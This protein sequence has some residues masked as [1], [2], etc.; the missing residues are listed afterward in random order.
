M[1]VA[2][3]AQ[4]RR[5]AWRL[6]SADRAGLTATLALTCLASAAGLAG[7]YLLG[8]IIDLLEA[9]R[10]TVAA[11]DGLAAA[12]LAC[13]LAQ[14]VLTRYARLGAFRFGERALARLR[15]EFVDRALALPARVVERSGTGDLTN[16]A[17]GDMGVIATTLRG[18]VPDVFPA[19]LQI[20]FLLAAVF[21]LSPSLGV[22]VLVGV[23]PVWWALHWYLRRSRAAYLAEGTAASTALAGVT[24]T[25]EGGRTVEALGLRRE[26]VAR[27][28]HDTLELY[29][30]RRRTLRLRSVLFPVA[31]AAFSLPAVVV[32]LYGGL[33]HLEGGMSLGVVVAC[34]LYM[35][36][37]EEPA[38]GIMY[39]VEQLQRGGA[40]FARV[41]GVGRVT[42]PAGAAPTPVDDRIEVRG[43]RY[44]YVA[45][46]D[47]LRGIDLT[48]RPGERLAVVGP[49]GAGKTT[50][51]RLLAGVDAPD[52]GSVL[53]GGVPVADL[54]P[55]ELRRRIVLVNQEHHVFAG[56][57]RE[58]L[59][60][61][62]E[63]ADDTALLSAL[64]AVD[65]DWLR[66]LPEGL[67]TP[68]GA[69][70][71]ALDA[72]GAQQLALARVVLADPHTVVL[73]EATSLLDP[74]TARAAERSLA[75]VLEGRTVI[76]IAHRL[77]TA[78]DADRVAVVEDGRI[79]EL[80]T[81]DELVGAGGAYAALWRSWHG[82][83]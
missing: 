37:M 18:A 26:R 19:L 58:N 65:A 48:V 28:D 46:T 10:A 56:T 60:L 41:R 43:A 57:L 3:P 16:R 34:C 35:R 38:S 61:A 23:P 33:L 80:G 31:E 4:A 78:H 77:H 59:A 68:L 30:T 75:A 7:P 52:S 81:H 1:P 8:R 17:S 5:D 83:A 82:T 45:G 49:S 53:V 44:A 24:A 20:L 21:W 79:T 67:D 22:L 40:S 70:G 62:S 69:G 66:E 54:G 13:A 55:E 14:L 71:T 32:L 63:K 6:V 27:T 73:D 72:A 47:V 15:E 11:V 76:A 9:G 29:G 39:W 36:Q 2:E 25:A 51:G 50:L 74:T 64:E 12:V 42:A